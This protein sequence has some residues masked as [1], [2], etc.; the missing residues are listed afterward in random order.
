MKSVMKS[1]DSSTGGDA[2]SRPLKHIPPLDLELPV[3]PA[4]WSEPPAGTWEDGYRLSLAALKSVQ[5]RTEIFA[6]RE[7]DR[8][9][10]EFVDLT[11]R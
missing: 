2:E 3:A 9:D 11:R 7:K 5:E 1:G 4:W 10:V 8:C 6:E